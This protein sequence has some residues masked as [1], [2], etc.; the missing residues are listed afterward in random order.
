MAD[1]IA[2][3]QL[4][5][6]KD[7]P[8]LILSPLGSY[9]TNLPVKLSPQ[10]NPQPDKSLYLLSYVL[11]VA[12]TVIAMCGRLIHLSEAERAKFHRKEFRLKCGGRLNGQSPRLNLQPQ[13]AFSV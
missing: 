10:K 1:L 9:D 13:V 12:G 8:P 4:P 2:E 7:T 6:R 3:S 5:G 11:G